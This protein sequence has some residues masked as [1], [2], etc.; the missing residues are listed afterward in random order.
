VPNVVRRT[1]FRRRRLVIGTLSAQNPIVYFDMD[2]ERL[3][4]PADWDG[5]VVVYLE[6]H[7]KTNDAGSPFRARLFNDTLGF[8]VS[9]S[10]LSTPAI[11]NTRARS[12]GF[13]LSAGSN[14]YHVQY[15]G[16]SGFT[17]TP[18]PNSHAVLI[19][20]VT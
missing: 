3:L 9:G 12:G 5:T 15:G 7:A 20:E 1:Y 14:V 4:D 10:E 8:A 2:N 16:V 13:S 18:D 6:V 11:V 19:I 17:Y